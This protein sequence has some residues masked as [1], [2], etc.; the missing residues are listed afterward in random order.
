MTAPTPAPEPKPRGLTRNVWSLGFVSL[1]TDV[2]SEMIVPV[3]PLFVTGTLKASVT[4]LGIIEGIAE[5]TASLLR[6]GSGWLS[7]RVGRRKPFLV[8]GYGLSGAAKVAF[9]A[10]TSWPAVLALRFADRVG[11]GLRTPPRDALLADSVDAAWRGRAFGLHRALDTLG[12]AVGP[13]VAFA[14]LA[15]WPGEYRRVFL[16]SAI[17][18]AL[19]LVVLL[20]LVRAP[21]TSPARRVRALHLEFRALPA[22]AKRFLIADGVFQLGNSSLAFVF[23]RARAGGLAPAAI[24]LVYL[25]YNVVYAALAL[26]A[27]MVADRRGR[28]PLLLAAYL[29]Y[30]AAYAA[31]AW[32]AAPLVVGAAMLVY[33]VH[34][35]LLEVSQRS[36]LADLVDAEARGTA[37]GIHHTVVGLALLPASVLAGWLWDL[38][39]AAVT[40]G[41]GAALA[42]VAAGL[43]AALLPGRHE[44]RD[45][46][47]A[48]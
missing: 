33:G 14:L 4:S 16:A 17:P 38:R 29:L 41:V 25:L 12:A 43:F 48:A 7:D 8:L 35:A 31:L 10:A 45:R 40:F 15:A 9:A 24:P 44:R 2:S 47:P 42:L 21:R 27:G 6:L 39:G 46:A 36:L 3:L 23:L 30:A 37:Y 18:A 19:S 20:A 5:S 26:P 32:S 1:L 34:S 13:L 28:R 11:K 22:P